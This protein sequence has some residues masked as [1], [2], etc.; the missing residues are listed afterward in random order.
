MLAIILIGHDCYVLLVLQFI[1]HLYQA[2]IGVM[3]SV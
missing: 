3:Q 2:E 1:I